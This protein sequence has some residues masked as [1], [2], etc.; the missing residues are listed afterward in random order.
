M[1]S[2]KTKTFA[3]KYDAGLIITNNII[4]NAADALYINATL[5]EWSAFPKRLKEIDKSAPV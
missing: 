4:T 5:K 1:R 3:T 2:L